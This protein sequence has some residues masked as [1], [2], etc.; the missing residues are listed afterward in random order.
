MIYGKAFAL[1]FF[2]IP[3]IFLIITNKFMA[4][5]FSDCA[6]ASELKLGLENPLK[7]FPPR[8]VLLMGIG[9]ILCGMVTWIMNC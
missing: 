8:G 9:L 6:K 5:I 1:F 7:N 3:G 4:K 2:I